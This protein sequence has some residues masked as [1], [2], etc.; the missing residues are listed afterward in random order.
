MLPVGRGVK[1]D[2]LLACK[3][4]HVGQFNQYLFSAFREDVF[5]LNPSD[6]LISPDR[7][8]Y[9]S[10]SDARRRKI[11]NEESLWQ[12]LQ[13]QG[14]ERVELE[15]MN[16]YNQL[17]LFKEAALV[18]SNHGAGLTNIAFMAQGGRVIELKSKNNDYWCYF[19]LSRVIGLKY[20]YI[21]CDG[22]NIDHRSA[23]IVVDVDAVLHVIKQ[24]LIN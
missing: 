21:L 8:L 19:S 17:K 3:V 10:R 16:W 20:A 12:S 1:I 5:A 24:D 9:I 4:P 2:R 15:G 22:N 11:L 7:K 14:F 13:H 23:D 6:Q 18:V